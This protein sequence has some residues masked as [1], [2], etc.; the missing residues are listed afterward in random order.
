MRFYLVFFLILTMAVGGSAIAAFADSGGAQVTVT[1][2]GYTV[3]GTYTNATFSQVLDGADHFPTYSLPFAVTDATGSGA[4]WNL[5]VSM[6]PVLTCN[7][8][9]CQ[10]AT[11]AQKLTAVSAP[12][13]V[14]GNTCTPITSVNNQLN[15]TIST[16]PTKFFS[17]AANTGLGSFNNGSATIQVSIPGNAYA[18]TYTGTIVLAA[19][20]GP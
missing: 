20:N 5:Q 6:N 19:S 2:G 15:F 1:G 3:T 18:G 16:S 12:T 8:G 7:S 10:N 13:C 17:A 4:G 14:N 9:A 11:L